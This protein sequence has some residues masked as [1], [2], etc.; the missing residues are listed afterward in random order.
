M[1]ESKKLR[2]AL[3][4]FKIIIISALVLSFAFFTYTMIDA[5]MD[6]LR[7]TESNTIDSFPLTYIFVV[8]IVGIITYGA[9]T[10]ISIV[11]LLISIFAKSSPKRRANIA[12]FVILSVAPA[13]CE[14]ILLIVGRLM[15]A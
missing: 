15:G 9:I 3:A 14:V 6:D 13:L 5:H 2:I 1:Q 8:L 10:L 12:S 4:V 7:D 11:G